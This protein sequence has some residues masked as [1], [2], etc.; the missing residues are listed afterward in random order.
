MF[1]LEVIFLL[2]RPVSSTTRLCLGKVKSPCFGSISYQ[3]NKS[4]LLA[5]KSRVEEIGSYTPVEIFER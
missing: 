1:F 3:R 2:R 5:Q 4:G